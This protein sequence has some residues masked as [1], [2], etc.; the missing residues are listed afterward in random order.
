MDFSV[1]NLWKCINEIDRGKYTVFAKN[2]GIPY[3]TVKDWLSGRSE[4]KKRN[5]DKL[6]E[7]TGKPNSFFYITENRKNHSSSD[8]K[9]MPEQPN[10]SH[11]SITTLPHPDLVS[12]F[13]NP[14]LG[15]EL[16]QLLI[17]IEHLNPDQL[18]HIREYLK[19]KLE[20]LEQLNQNGIQTKIAANGDI[21]ESIAVSERTGAA[22]KEKT[23][24][25][26]AG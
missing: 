26:T 15:R 22:P 12:L 13:R 3:T 16:N 18:K 25:G 20:T 8:E 6:T 21:T 5:L 19:I 10:I 7:Y 14:E 11:D 17:K 4:P 9:T 24:T 2:A 1:D 23:K